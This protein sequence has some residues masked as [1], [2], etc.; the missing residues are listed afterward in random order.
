MIDILNG[1]DNIEH[2]RQEIKHIGN[3]EDNFL[4]DNLGNLINL[5]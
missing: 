5:I 3:A 4:N 1:E 2:I